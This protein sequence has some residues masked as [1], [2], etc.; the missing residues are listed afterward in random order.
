MIKE[1]NAGFLSAIT[2]W[3][4]HI[5][6]N[7]WIPDRYGSSWLHDSRGLMLKSAREYAKIH[8]IGIDRAQRILALQ[9]I[10][11]DF[12]AFLIRGI[13]KL[14]MFWSS[15]FFIL[16]YIFHTAYPPMHPAIVVTI[17]S[18]VLLSYITIL[19]LTI[20]GFLIDTQIPKRSLLLFL[21]IGGMIPAVVTFGISRFHLPLLSIMLPVAGHGAVNLK[22]KI[23]FPRKLIILLI[24]LLFYISIFTSLPLV[25]SAYLRPSTYY[26]EL[27][28]QIDKLLGS[29]TTCIDKVIF[30][31]TTEARDYLT[32][33]IQ[34][35]GY[36]FHPSQPDPWIHV[37]KIKQ[38]RWKISPEH[39]ILSLDVYSKDSSESLE[40]SISSERLKQSVIIQPIRKSTWR[41][42]QPSGLKGIDYMWLGGGWGVR[43]K[44]PDDELFKF[45]F[46]SDFI[47]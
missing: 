5:G 8:S 47:P 36:T 45:R 25:V 33:A 2:G 46:T 43:Q 9:E 14:R 20:C 30:R 35:K 40:I 6:N 13:Y 38:Y 26:C 29:N 44:L 11:K 4:L 37:P 16:Q 3:Y 39:K 31:V 34:S 7:P 28:N 23:S 27:I 17:W 10:K 21:I 19:M 15:D 32:I 22:Q 18:I 24:T 1:K 12:K 42:W 41:H